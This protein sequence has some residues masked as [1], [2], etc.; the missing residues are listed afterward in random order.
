MYY[1]SPFEAYAAID[2]YERTVAA[3]RIA[4]EAMSNTA[5][6]ATATKERTTG[7]DWFS[8]RTP[9]AVFSFGRHA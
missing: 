2:E 4:R 7:R 1:Y 3:H 8:R 6:A 9:L 5:D